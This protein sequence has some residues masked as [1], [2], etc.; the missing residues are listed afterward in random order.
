MDEGRSI[1]AQQI[2]ITN[3]SNLSLSRLPFLL[4][5]DKHWENP[6]VSQDVLQDVNQYMYLN[7]IES[8]QPVI[9]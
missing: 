7:F 1:L 2:F 3:I 6:S 5:S 4:F 8:W 9:R